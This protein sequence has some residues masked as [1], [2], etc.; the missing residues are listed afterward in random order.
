MGVETGERE[1]EVRATARNTGGQGDREKD[2][3]SGWPLREGERPANPFD[4]IGE[5]LQGYLAYKKQ[6]PLPGPP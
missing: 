5:R 2:R 1:R 6:P 4:Q 3:R